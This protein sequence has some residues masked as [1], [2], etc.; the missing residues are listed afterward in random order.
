MDIKHFFKLKLQEYFKNR[1]KVPLNTFRKDFDSDNFENVALLFPVR[2]KTDMDLLRNVVRKAKK[3]SLKITVL[4][5]S[6]T[7]EM[8]DLITDRNLFIFNAD[9]FN[10]KWQ[11]ND[12]LRQ[13]LEK[14][15]FD[16]L[17]NFDFNG[18]F[19]LKNLHNLINAGFKIANQNKNLH[20]FCDL[21]INIDMNKINWEAFYTLAIRNLQ[22]LKIKKNDTR[23]RS[24][25]SNTL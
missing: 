25:D 8:P 6:Y 13:W 16:L 22:M 1:L 14:R 17:I 18:L 9:S 21:T 20:N 12:D 4:V 7:I 24:S 19:E 15:K 23:N 11:P 10:Y 5:F 3:D 2:G